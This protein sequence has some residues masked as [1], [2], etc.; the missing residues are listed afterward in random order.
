MG[1]GVHE[2]GGE[3]VAIK[4]EYQLGEEEIHDVL[5]NERRK[6]TLELLK[7]ETG[8][9]ELRTLA[10]W[11][12]EAESGESPPPK[13]VR[14]SVYNSLHQTH[15]PKLDDHG[16]VDYQTD[17]KIISLRP[18]ARRVDLYMEVLTP[19]GI[20]WSTYYRTL[21]VLAL[22]AIIADRMDALLF[23]GEYTMLIASAFLLVIAVSTAYQLWSNNWIQVRGLLSD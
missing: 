2:V 11:I 5:S 13:N 9:V 21:A 22:S 1:S 17:R 19:Y 14:Q 12:A 6:R 8:S 20:T 3:P 23:P 15:L 4:S 18:K 10:E 7:E 16:I